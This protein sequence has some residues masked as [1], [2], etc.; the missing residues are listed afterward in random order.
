M[1]SFVLNTAP[2]QMAVYASAVGRRKRCE[3]ESRH[4]RASLRA[5]IEAPRGA[6]SELGAEQRNHDEFAMRHLQQC[7]LHHDVAYSSNETKL[8][9]GHRER[10]SFEAKRF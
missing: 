3:S 9:D 10:V 5:D 8:S 6:Y 2:K 7:G 1:T 4:A